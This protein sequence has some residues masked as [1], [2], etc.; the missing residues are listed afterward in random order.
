M[1]TKPFLKPKRKEAG[2]KDRGGDASG[3]TVLLAVT[4]MSPAVLTETVWALAKQKGKPVIPDRVI[5]LTTLKGKVEIEKQLFGPDRIWDALRSTLLG[6]AADS[7]ERLYFGLSADCVRVFTRNAGGKPVEMADI[8]TEEESM[9]VA[10]FITEALWAFADRPNTNLIASIAGGFKTMSALLFACMSLLGHEDDRITHVL[11]TAPYD[12]ALSP[13]FY[14]PTQPALELKDSGGNTYMADKAKITLSDIPFVAL[15]SLLER[16]K[17]PRSYSALVR[18][19]RGEVLAVAPPPEIIF[20]D[21]H[22]VVRIGR[23]HFKLDGRE[24]PLFAFL[25]K[26]AAE[27]LE[28][29]PDHYAAVEPF[30]AF[31]QQWAGSH[32]GY[33]FRER[34]KPEKD[35]DWKQTISNDFFKNPLSRIR[36]KL[37]NAGCEIESVCPRKKLGLLIAPPRKG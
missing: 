1:K 17:K 16:Y 9:A 28:P 32:P 2:A 33:S 23:R 15:G 14:F 30:K 4:G 5:V 20:D 11:V 7:D 10:D 6:S 18:A 36:D 21:K 26:R 24:H 19:C 34:D 37:K 3:K 29:F 22:G 31:A 27:N 25:Y 13:R 12:T 8:S 35:S